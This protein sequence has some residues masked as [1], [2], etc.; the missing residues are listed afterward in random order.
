MKIPDCVFYLY[1]RGVVESTADTLTEIT[2]TLKDA[3]VLLEGTKDWLPINVTRQLVLQK[4][5]IRNEICQA[6]PDEMIYL[7][8]RHECVD[9][10]NHLKLVSIKRDKGSECII[11]PQ[12]ASTDSFLHHA[13]KTV[14]PTI[15]YLASEEDHR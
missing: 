10:Q 2:F 14:H 8:L 13:L 5:N 11:H 9:G 15:F 4:A 12:E 6:E 7:T 1:V 3:V